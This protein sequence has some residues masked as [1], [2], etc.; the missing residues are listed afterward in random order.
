MP[1]DFFIGTEASHAFGYDSVYIMSGRYPVGRFENLP[2]FPEVTFAT[3]AVG[4]HATTD[5]PVSPRLPSV[6][7]LLPPR[8]NP[9]R[10][11]VAIEFELPSARQVAVDLYDVSGRLVWRLVPALTYSAGRHVFHWDGRDRGGR[12][13][14][15]GIYEARM[16]SGDVTKSRKFAVVR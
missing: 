3:R 16:V 9:T 6:I 1:R 12:A 8:P 11:G 15:S 13:A 5:A 14:A 10:A 7:A 2:A 4:P